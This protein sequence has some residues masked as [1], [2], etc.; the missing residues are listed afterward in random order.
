MFNFRYY[1]IDYVAVIPTQRNKVKERNG[2][3]GDAGLAMLGNCFFDECSC[4]KIHAYYPSHFSS[5]LD[6]SS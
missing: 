6:F 3:R 5:Q 1:S 4:R 2:L